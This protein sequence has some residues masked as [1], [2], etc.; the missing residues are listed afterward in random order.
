[1]VI[2][3][4]STSKEIVVDVSKW[5]Q[6]PDKFTLDLSNEDKG[7]YSL[8]LVYQVDGNHIQIM[9]MIDNK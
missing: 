4:T 3:N 7:Y 1:M 8:I 9:S 2:R 5:E 6:N